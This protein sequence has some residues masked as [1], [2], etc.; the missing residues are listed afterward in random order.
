MQSRTVSGASSLV[1]PN[2]SSVRSVASSP[3][4]LPP[5]SGN[6]SVRSINSLNDT[7][8]LPMGQSVV[9][10]SASR[11]SAMSPSS[12]RL[13]ILP[14]DNSTGSQS[15]RLNL[16]PNDNSAGSLYHNG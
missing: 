15:T 11:T 6:N 7:D 12:T 3:W 4:N 13:N 9:M 5:A 2:N 14:N 16:L 8:Q 10:R 1:P